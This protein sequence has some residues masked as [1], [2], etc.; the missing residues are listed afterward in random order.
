MPGQLAEA[1]GM[2][3]HDQGEMY[4]Y[5]GKQVEGGRRMGRT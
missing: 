2:N 3:Y 5:L 4:S 1:T